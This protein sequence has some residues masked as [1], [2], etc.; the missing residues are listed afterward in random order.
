MERSESYSGKGAEVGGGPLC[1][2]GEKML[3]VFIYNSGTTRITAVCPKTFTHP[4]AENG[5]QYLV[6]T[7]P[8]HAATG[9]CNV[10]RIDG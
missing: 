6:T 2:C 5:H 7:T 8:E 4:W 9:C 10:Q 1:R 3:P